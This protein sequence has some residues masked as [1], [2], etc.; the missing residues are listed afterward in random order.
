MPTF[1]RRQATPNASDKVD[2][3]MNN[4]QA[5]QVACAHFVAKL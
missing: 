2:A 4:I 5:N 3:K 1:R